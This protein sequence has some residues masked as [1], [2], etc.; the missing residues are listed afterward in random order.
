M[1]ST[2]AES[3]PNIKAHLDQLASLLKC[4]FLGTPWVRVEGTGHP[5]SAGIQEGFSS[6]KEDCRAQCQNAQV[7]VNIT[8]LCS[9]LQVKSSFR[10]SYLFSSWV[11]KIPWRR[12]CR[13]TLVFLPGK[14][15]EQRS[16]L[17]YSPWGQ[18]RQI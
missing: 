17:D 4:R 1:C 8:H 3:V 12:K 11:R 15:H 9:N 14:S 7:L 16:L 13:P 2:T 10:T 6:W 18:K 5:H